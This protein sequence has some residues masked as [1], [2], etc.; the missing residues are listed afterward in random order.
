M[1]SKDRLSSRWSSG[2]AKDVLRRH[3]F[4]ADPADPRVARGFLGSLR[5]YGGLIE[6][7]FHEV[8]EALIALA[9]ELSDGRRVDREV[10][11][12]LW[13]ICH[14][15]RSWG[16]HPEGML[17]RNELIAPHDVERLE[18]WVETISYAVTSLLDGG[19]VEEAFADYHPHEA[20]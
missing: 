15:A 20:S 3:A 2:E 16:V 8:M 19:P 5:P 1:A 17:R 9:P 11:S 14:F 18:E 6:E 7:N 4:Q 12:A 13:G 10:M